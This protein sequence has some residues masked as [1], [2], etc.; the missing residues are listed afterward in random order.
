MLALARGEISFHADSPPSY[1]TKVEPLVKTGELIV[2]YYDPGFNGTE[3]RVPRQIRGFAMQPFHEFY[4]SVK[5]K[6]PS[7]DLWEAYKTV[8]T[9]NG[10]MYRLPAMPPAAP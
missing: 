9:V 3:F 10:T 5:G 8:L 4:K 1:V 6:M 7:G 2:P